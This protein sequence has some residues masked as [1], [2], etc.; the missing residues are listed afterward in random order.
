MTHKEYWEKYIDNS[1]G[2]DK[3]EKDE[4][5]DI[6]RDI[7]AVN[8]AKNE[9]IADVQ[10]NRSTYV[11]QSQ[12]QMEA[13]NKKWHSEIESHAAKYAESLGDIAKIKETPAGATADVQAEI[14]RHND[15]I[16]S[17]KQHLESIAPRVSN[18]PH[19]FIETLMDAAR[20]RAMDDL[21]KETTQKLETVTK[22]RDD[23]QK[24]LD[25][26]KNSSSTA[27]KGIKPTLKP[28]G[29]PRGAST[30]D[31]MKNMMQEEGILKR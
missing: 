14:K 25:T 26:I 22:Q 21:Q 2:L 7:R 18:D 19:V 12:E 15:R 16:Q 13:A 24:Q 20:A 6:F 30:E 28:S 23:L 11:K 29:P 4:L 9:K 5:D 31:I 1:N 8:R 27:A 10:K 17:A 3:S